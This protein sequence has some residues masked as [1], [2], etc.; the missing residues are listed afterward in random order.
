MNASF[1]CASIMMTIGFILI[2]E[3]GNGICPKELGARKT[4]FAL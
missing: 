2:L 1:R 3:G 4:I